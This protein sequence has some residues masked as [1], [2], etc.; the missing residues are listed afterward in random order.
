MTNVFLDR[1]LNY[2]VCG[3]VGQRPY[4]VLVHRLWFCCF[5]RNQ[6]GTKLYRKVTGA[7]AMEQGG[8]P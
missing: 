5:V 4:F 1:G 3:L 2:G 6:D 7:L 8:V